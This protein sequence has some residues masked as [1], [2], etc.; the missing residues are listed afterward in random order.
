MY[1][2]CTILQY[3]LI[4]QKQIMLISHIK[5]L[6][7]QICAMPSKIPSLNYIHKLVF[8]MIKVFK[9]TIVM[10]CAIKMYFYQ[11]TTDIHVT[12]YM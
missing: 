8:D 6:S 3:C 9:R 10:I 7:N 4:Y 2:Y 12:A 5:V 11:I 1:F